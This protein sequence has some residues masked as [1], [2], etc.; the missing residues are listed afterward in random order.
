MGTSLVTTEFCHR[1]ESRIPCLTQPF[2]AP[3]PT[4]GGENL[5]GAE[6][7]I[8][9]SD[10][11]RPPCSHPGLYFLISENCCLI[12]FI[13]FII[14]I[15]FIIFINLITLITTLFTQTIK[16]ILRII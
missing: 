5:H 4:F 6:P 11:P 12:I 13:N 8:G 3:L 2:V 16:T 14:L 10:L 9:G 7:E 1:R 15:N